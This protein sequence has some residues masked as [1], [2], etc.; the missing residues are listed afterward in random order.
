MSQTIAD[1]Y[2]YFVQDVKTGA[3]K[4]GVTRNLEGR[5]KQLR[6]ANPNVAPIGEIRG[7]PEEERELHNELNRYGD[8]GEW[9]RGDARVYDVIERELGY[10]PECL[11]E[12]RQRDAA[13]ALRAYLRVLSLPGSNAEA[14]TMAYDIVSILEEAGFEVRRRR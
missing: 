13:S 8:G 10:R 3:V 12:K 7:G 6:N 14:D 5:L 11:R 4:V 9:F 1:S 2:V